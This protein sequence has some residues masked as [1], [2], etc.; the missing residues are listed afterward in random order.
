MYYMSVILEVSTKDFLT[1]GN[2]TQSL[3][4]PEVN[5]GHLGLRFQ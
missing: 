1:K 3:F 2:S 5:E 4:L